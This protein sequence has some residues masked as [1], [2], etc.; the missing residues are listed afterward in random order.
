MLV[1]D[2]DVMTPYT[3]VHIFEY[4]PIEFAFLIWECLIIVN[5]SKRS[6]TFKKYERHPD[7]RH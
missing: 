1:V 5:L 3:A 7:I 2:F 4:L 6:K